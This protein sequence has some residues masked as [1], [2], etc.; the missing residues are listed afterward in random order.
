VV[1]VEFREGEGEMRVELFVPI[2]ISL[3]LLF[4]VKCA[5][6]LL[7]VVLINCICIVFIVLVYSLLLGSFM[8][9]VLLE[10]GIP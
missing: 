8:C 1:F 7:I 2:C 10:R 4:S 9:S 5:Y 3:Q 6:S